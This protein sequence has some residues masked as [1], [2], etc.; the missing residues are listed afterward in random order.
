MKKSTIILIGL[1]FAHDNYLT[2]HV[3]I[4]SKKF[5]VKSI[6]VDEHRLLSKCFKRRSFLS[7]PLELFV[8]LGLLLW[9][10]PTAVI[11][12]G[13]KIGLL[14]SITCR[15]LFIKSYHWFTGQVWALKKHRYTSLAY[16]CD[17]IVYSLSSGVC[18]DGLTQK[19][20]LSY[21]F[22]F[23]RNI[24]V[25]KNGSINGVREEFYSMVHTA[26]Y[27]N[28]L[29]VC[30]IGRKTN[31]KGLSLLYEVAKKTSDLD[32]NCLFTLA[33]P[34]DIDSSQYDV[35]LKN[36]YSLS[37]IKLIDDYVNPTNTLQD[38][39]V[40]ILPSEREGFGSIVVEAQA[41]GLP[42]ICSDAYGLSD[43]FI[44][45]ITGIRCKGGM[46]NEYVDAIVKLNDA[47]IL[48]EFSTQARIFSKK[49]HPESFK[50]DLSVCYA[51]LGIL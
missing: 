9:N 28:I 48:S 15:L 49:F 5:N 32:I 50:R 18:C 42:V 7:L 16:W 47:I 10:R 31:G 2:T 34:V 8:L 29:K 30:F 13:P 51:E 39:H 20:F 4:L 24:H 22:P 45:G 44:D 46:V 43:S 12:I 25:P 40:L 23:S 38:Q 14:S 37:N 6:R 3:E 26:K 36:Q 1:S 33:G 17:L 21:N 19:T 11:S 27:K 41:I 35:F